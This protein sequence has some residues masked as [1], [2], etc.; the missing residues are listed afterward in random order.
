MVCGCCTGAVQWVCHD[1]TDCAVRGHL[2]KHQDSGGFASCR[3]WLLFGIRMAHYCPVCSSSWVAASEVHLTAWSFNGP[4]S[5]VHCDCPANWRCDGAGPAL[6][7][8]QCIVTVLQLCSVAAQGLQH[9]CSA[10]Q[11]APL[12]GSMHTW[13]LPKTAQPEPTVAE[14]LC[15][16][17]FCSPSC[18][19]HDQ[20]AT[21]DVLGRCL[22]PGWN[23]GSWPSARFGAVEVSLPRSGS[24]TCSPGPCWQMALPERA[25][26]PVAMQPAVCMGPAACTLLLSCPFF[27]QLVHIVLCCEGPASLWEVACQV[28]DTRSALQCVQ[29]P[30][31]CNSVC[32]RL[33]AVTVCAAACRL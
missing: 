23:V 25:A 31:G 8:V 9:H 29:P 22:T 19:V 17:P 10:V 18:P 3:W 32:S 4:E 2:Q 16:R 5:A 26:E 1:V 33:Q 11:S 20:A 28:G 7:K 12:G 13:A 6:L 24:R 21:R 15:C 27:Q 14:N 30:A